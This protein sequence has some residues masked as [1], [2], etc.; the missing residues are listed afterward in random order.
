MLF[1]YLAHG[2]CE[3]NS[4][5]VTRSSFNLLISGPY[6][7]Q[8]VSQLVGGEKGREGEGGVM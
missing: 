2:G 8:S 6:Q 7:Q 4:R 5:D 3:K 1:Y